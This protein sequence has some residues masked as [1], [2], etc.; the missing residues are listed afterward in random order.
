MSDAIYVRLKL[1]K[2]FYDIDTSAFLF[3]LIKEGCN[4]RIAITVVSRDLMPC[5]T[6]MCVVSLADSFNF[7]LVN[8]L[9]GLDFDGEVDEYRPEPLYDRLLNLQELFQWMLQERIVK[10]IEVLFTLDYDV[11]DLETVDMMLH[12]FAKE[13]EPMIVSGRL[14]QPELHHRFVWSK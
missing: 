2:N 1:K 9:V 7:E 6:D 11:E 3:G 10:N 13:F 12:D 8:P 5:K 4:R 14:S